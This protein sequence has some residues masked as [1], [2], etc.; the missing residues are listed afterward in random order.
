[1]PCS[2]Q[3]MNRNP[4]W[5]KEST[6]VDIASNR[7]AASNTCGIQLCVGASYAGSVC[8][9]AF[10]SHLLGKIRFQLT[11]KHVTCWTWHLDFKFFLQSTSYQC[12][13]KCVHGYLSTWQFQHRKVE[14]IGWPWGPSTQSAAW[15]HAPQDVDD[16]V[17]R[18][19][20]SFY[21]EAPRET[22]LDPQYRARTYV[23]HARIEIHGHSCTDH[24]RAYPILKFAWWV[25]RCFSV[26]FEYLK[27]SDFRSCSALVA[28]RVFCLPVFILLSNFHK[29]AWPTSVFHFLGPIE[30]QPQPPGFSTPRHVDLGDGLRPGPQDLKWIN[31]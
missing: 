1:M 25:L 11:K 31:G 29:H 28:C 26:A 20:L 21:L 17:E 18:S 4:A 24:C 5:L 27:Q 8:V 6:L 12:E 13:F 30:P 15:S 3:S 10:S 9:W 7:T 22:R 2:F 23:D 14:C 19:S 16:S